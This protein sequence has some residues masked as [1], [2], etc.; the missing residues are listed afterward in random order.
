MSADER[1][2]RAVAVLFAT[3]VLCLSCS[4]GVVPSSTTAVTP[5]ADFVT[6]TSAGSLD[7]LGA[8]EGRDSRGYP[9]GGEAGDRV[10]WIALAVKSGEVPISGVG[11]FEVMESGGRRQLVRGTGGESW[12]IERS[13]STMRVADARGRDATPW[14]PGPFIVRVRGAHALVA[15]D[16]TRYRGELWI[17][18]TDSGLL[19]VNRLPVED[20]LRGV[21]PLELGTRSPV[22]AAALQA[23]AV[24]ARSYSYVR[25]PSREVVPPSGF[26]MYA[27]VQNQV[28]GGV[29]VEHAVV[30]AAIASTSGLVLRFEGAVVDG[31]YS[32]SC[33]GRTA[34]PT[35]VWRG[36]RDVGY[37]QSVS[38][39]DARTGRP[40]CDISPRNAWTATFDEPL[41]RQAIVRHLGVRGAPGSTA[42]V[43]QKIAVGRRTAT[44]RV[45]TLVVN[46]DRGTVTLTGADAR[47]AFRDARGAS[48]L[49]TYF[50]VER[51]TRVGGRVSAVVLEGAGHGHGVGMCQWGAIGRAR[52]GHDVRAILR[53]YYPG[54]VVGFAE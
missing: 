43:V 8:V 41:L 24:A 30:D 52:A 31:P 44:G 1:G 11:A 32:S 13:G 53:H 27:T 37:L 49:S 39:I 45:G 29:A 47:N 4:S 54:T 42:P 9:V 6:D 21:V 28:Y 18:S 36:S 12:R 7:L 2:L 33:G 40:Y 50:E 19:V 48:L 46:T 23:Q 16:G 38:D 10:A 5:S 26:H 15:H 22:D 25:V 14:R 3:M 17:T 34:V 35:D 20:Y 51:E